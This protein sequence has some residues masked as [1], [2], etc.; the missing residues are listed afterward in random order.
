VFQ[1]PAR[2]AIAV[3]VAATC[4]TV[5]VHSSRAQTP[6]PPNSVLINGDFEQVDPN[7]STL[8]LGWTPLATLG[9]NNHA[10]YQQTGNKAIQGE[11]FE[12]GSGG[13]SCSIDG[14]NFKTVQLAAIDPT[15][16]YTLGFWSKYSINPSYPHAEVRVAAHIEFYDSTNNF[17]ASSAYQP[18]NAAA[19]Q[20]EWAFYH[21]SFGPAGDVPFPSSTAKIRLKFVE[22]GPSGMSAN[23]V[24]DDWYGRV[25]IDDASFAP[26]STL[27]GID[28]QPNFASLANAAATNGTPSPFVVAVVASACVMAM[29]AAAGAATLFVRRR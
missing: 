24:P 6:P 3:L 1:R 10:F 29:M 7:N 4:F 20:D 17:I 21:R 2:F 16:A 18:V 14:N 5:A 19:A 27:G 25:T 13:T 26:S 9:P 15:K 23:C 11:T 8:P 22:A 12:A 28:E